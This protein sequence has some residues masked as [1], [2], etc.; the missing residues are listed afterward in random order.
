MVTLQLLPVSPVQIDT[1]YRSTT[2]SETT[3]RRLILLSLIYDDVIL[4]G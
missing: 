4:I 1:A 2:V 3:K